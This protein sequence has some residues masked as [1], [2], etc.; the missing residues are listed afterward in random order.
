MRQRSITG[1]VI[2]VLIGIVFLLNNLG[3]NLPIW[4]LAWD[5]WPLLLVVIG[6][7]GLVEVLYHVG[8]GG[9]TPSRGI[10]FGGIF[11]IIVLV[12][13]FSWA[14]RHGNIH[15]GPFTN[16]GVNILGSDYEYDVNATGASQGV[17]RLVLDNVRGNISLKGEDGNGDVKVSGR[18]TVRA[19]SRSDADRA[20]QQSAI[21]ID[22]QGDELIVRAEEPGGSR[23]LSVSTD[24]DI[25]VPKNLDVEARGR[26][27][28]FTVDSIDGLVDV[29]SG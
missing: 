22:R 12:A 7:I 2:L 14:G 9:T 6:V 8:R 27:G 19:F 1:P 20:N 18:K 15:I 26:T 21:H 17:T 29:E 28:D 13:F 25:T 10:G 5:Y 16:G 11:W 4:S 23:M 24:L 3:H